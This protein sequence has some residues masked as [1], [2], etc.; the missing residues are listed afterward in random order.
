MR[1]VNDHSRKEAGF[2][3]TQEEAGGVELC[4]AMYEASQYR[5]YSPGNHDPC[6]PFPRAPTFNDNRA[7]YLEQNVGEVKH[8]YAKAVHTIAEAQ[9]STHS[10]IRERNVDPINVIHHVDEEHERK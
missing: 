2:C 10:E 1:Q 8:P 6:N 3:K 5:Y 7:W 4:G 9:V